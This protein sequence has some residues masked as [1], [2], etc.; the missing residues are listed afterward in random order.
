MFEL[1]FI[2]MKDLAFNPS[3]FPVIMNLKYL[4][5][6]CCF[7]FTVCHSVCSAIS[8]FGATKWLYGLS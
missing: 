2:F 6:K 4:K 7:N 8:T 5:N 1:L 3:F